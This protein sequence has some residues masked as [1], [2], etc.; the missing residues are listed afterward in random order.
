MVL[1]FK[2]YGLSRF[3]T[4]T[5]ILQILGSLGLTVGFFIPAVTLVSS[6]G[7]SVQMLLGVGVRIRIK[8]SF[9]QTF[10]ALFFC[11]LN[12]FIFWRTCLE[13]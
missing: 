1:E 13:Q 11:L 7:L 10:P 5:G 3:R 9:F 2:R 4:L 6:L 12:L 8:D